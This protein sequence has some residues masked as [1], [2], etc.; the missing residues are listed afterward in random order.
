APRGGRA[1]PFT[2]GGITGYG[3]A[4]SIAGGS[5]AIFSLPPARRLFGRVGQYDTIDVKAAAGVSPARLRAEVARVLPAGV[6]AVTAASASA[7][8]ARQL[9]SQLGVLTTFFAAFAGV[10]MF[11]GAFVIWNTFSLMIG[12]RSPQ[13]APPPALGASPRPDFPS[14]LA[15]AAL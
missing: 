12:Q 11:V 14:V 13:L 4:A 6:Q 1:P 9:N 7:T 10:A 5:M 8:E 2:I 3:G 15:E